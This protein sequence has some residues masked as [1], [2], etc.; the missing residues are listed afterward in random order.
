MLRLYEKFPRGY[1]E[2]DTGLPNCF[3]AK[4]ILIASSKIQLVTQ[5]DT[6]QTETGRQ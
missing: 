5:I 2:E 1:H 6:Y 4:T 3:T